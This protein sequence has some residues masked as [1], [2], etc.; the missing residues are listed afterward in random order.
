M[1]AT[2]EEQGPILSTR[3]WKGHFM[4]HAVQNLVKWPL[5]ALMLVSSVACTGTPRPA[6]E[7]TIPGIKNQTL[8]INEIRAKPPGLVALDIARNMLGVPYR[9]GG[10]DPRGFDCSGLVQY[11]FKNAGVE[12]PRTSRDIFRRSQLINPKDLR[13][14]DL[15]FFAISSN[16]VSHV[17]IYDGHKRFIHAPSSGKGVSYASLDNSYW[18]KRLVGAGRL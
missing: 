18:R 4:S 8:L 13:P 6:P 2:C 5:F 10:N 12:L 9:Y 14:G 16:K 7:A 17:G 15:V 1:F 3:A 11:T